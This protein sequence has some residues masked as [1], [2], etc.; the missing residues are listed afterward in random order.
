MQRRRAR[1][2][3]TLSGCGPPISSSPST[4]NDMHRFSSLSGALAGA[5]LFVVACSR[6]QPPPPHPIPAVTVAAVQER[7]ITE[8]DEFTGRFEAVESVELRP[9]V[10]GYVQHVAASE[11]KQV[12]K[13][14]L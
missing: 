13:G 3:G 10:S 11:G 4:E 2:P 9:H 5:A 7:T 1:R 6:A 14:D 8:W 12:K